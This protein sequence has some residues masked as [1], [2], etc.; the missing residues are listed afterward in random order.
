MTSSRSQ[1]TAAHGSG[2]AGGCSGSLARTSPGATAG[3]T[4][5][6]STPSMWSAIQ[7]ISSWPRARNSAPST[8]L[9]L[10]V[11]LGL[12]GLAV[13]P[14]EHDDPPPD[15]RHRQCHDDEEEGLAPATA[16]LAAA[17]RLG[18]GADALVEV[19]VR[20]DER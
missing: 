2:S 18:T 15:E 3:A 6:R 9:R 16:G 11:R 5:R 14:H 4:G 10:L 7:S 19:L 1:R 13:A 20:W 8:R 12:D 17:P